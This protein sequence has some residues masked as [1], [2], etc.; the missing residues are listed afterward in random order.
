MVWPLCCPLRTVSFFPQRADSLLPSCGRVERVYLSRI[1]FFKAKMLLIYD[2]VSFCCL[3]NW[4]Y[5]P[6]YMPP[7]PVT[8]M[9]EIME[10][11]PV[12][13]QE[14]FTQGLF[15]CKVWIIVINEFVLFCLGT[16]IQILHIYLHFPQ[17]TPGHLLATLLC[18]DTLHTLGRL[19]PSLLLT[20]RKG[21][22][23]G[24]TVP[25]LFK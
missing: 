14:P 9:P 19:A 8:T 24:N 15:I 18:W 13:N 1:F 16:Y 4:T 2:F 12:Q 21:W 17:K 23:V 7:H 22:C 11:T 6:R 25:P 3:I 5:F 20:P 10:A